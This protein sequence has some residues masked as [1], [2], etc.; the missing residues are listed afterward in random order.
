MS[1]SADVL[2]YRALFCTGSI[3]FP[4]QSSR[5]LSSSVD[6]CLLRR[7]E[8]LPPLCFFLS[9]GAFCEFA[10]NYSVFLLFVSF[11]IES[12]VTLPTT[13]FTLFPFYFSASIYDYSCFSLLRFLRN[14]QYRLRQHF[15][16]R[17]SEQCGRSLCSHRR[18]CYTRFPRFPAVTVVAVV[19]AAAF[20]AASCFTSAFVGQPCY[21]FAM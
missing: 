15:L 20:L 18:S 9:E 10:T 19:V 4:Q 21:S 12:P 2:T 16:Q 6:L 1:F 5:Q 3:V 11:S 7:V 8:P 17:P 14:K 13:T